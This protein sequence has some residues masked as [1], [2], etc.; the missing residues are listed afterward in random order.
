[1]L[2]NVEMT[3]KDRLREARKTR[4]LSQG[5]VGGWLGVSTQAVSQWEQGQTSPDVDKIMVLAERLGVPVAWLLGQ[6]E[7]DPP[8]LPPALS[9]AVVGGPVALDTT[10]KLFGQAAAG[11][12]GEFILNGNTAADIPAPPVLR[13]VRN[14]YAVYV[15]GDSM[16]PRYFSGEV[17][18]VNPLQPARRGD[19]VVAQIGV[20]E[21][22]APHAF[23]KRLVSKEGRVLRLEQFKPAKRLEFP[24]SKVV[25]VHRIIGM[26]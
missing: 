19:F 25:S 21:G 20:S 26:G 23:V 7:G 3:F 1:M 6:I 9:N 10:I 8:P 5:E 14:A 2:Y 11:L 17:V 12:D 4:K 15:V 24:M 16:E 18:Y 13:G 22:E